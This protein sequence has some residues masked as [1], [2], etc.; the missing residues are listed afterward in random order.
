MSRPHGGASP[1]RDRVDVLH[2]ASGTTGGWR[3]Y[4][5]LLAESLERLGLSVHR[6]GISRPSGGWIKRQ[7]YLGMDL[8]DALAMVVAAR[9]GLRRVQPRAIFYST[10]HGTIFQPRRREP[11]AVWLDGPIAIMRPGR[12]AAPLRWIERLRSRRLTLVLPISVQHPARLAEPLRPRRTIPL[13]IPVEPSDGPA[14]PL[15]GVLP[16]YGVVYAA[17]APRKKGLDLAVAAWDASSATGSLVVTG[18]E[19]DDARRF[20]AGAGVRPSNRVVFAGRVP[21]PEHRALIRE[22]AVYVSASRRE[23]YGT[24][25]L[26]ALSDGVPVAA[27]PSAGAPEPV[28]VI[29]RLPG[30][31]VATEVSV[32]ALTRVIDSALEMTEAERESY[33]H[34]ARAVMAG[35]GREAFERRLANE[36]VPVLLPS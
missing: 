26:E 8:Y 4:D 10:S 22:A 5:L 17:A 12:K 21:A 11:E 3:G 1:P 19:P 36:V 35:Y 29:R 13:P 2:V 30:D 34:A 18:A 24:T 16:P 15:G 23:E 32:A 27:V 28:A 20:L 33:R 25:Q 9:R 14:P 6:V 31:L 7:S